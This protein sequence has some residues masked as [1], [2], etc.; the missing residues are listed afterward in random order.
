MCK[1]TNLKNSLVIIALLLLAQYSVGPRAWGDSGK[2]LSWGGQ[3]T[4]TS[5][6]ASISAIAAGRLH[7]LALKA[8]GTIVGWGSNKF[9]QAIPP[10]GNEF[11]AVSAGGDHSL[12]LKADGSIAGWGYNRSGQAAPPS[13]NDFVAIA[14]GRYHSPSRPTVASSD[15]DVMILVRQYHLRE[16]TLWPSPQGGCTVL[17]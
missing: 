16:M 5:Q 13:A 2:I 1:R 7:S 8:D 3:I 11:V 10:S 4:P 12:A 14:A 15:G 6:L 9:R 17:P